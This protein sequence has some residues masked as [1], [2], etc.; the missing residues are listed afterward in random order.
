MSFDGGA[1]ITVVE[2]GRLGGAARD[3][4]TE[5]RVAGISMN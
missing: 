1:A 5:G 3:C 4:G 2:L